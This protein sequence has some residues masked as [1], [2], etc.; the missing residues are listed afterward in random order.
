MPKVAIT[1]VERNRM[2]H[3]VNTI[4]TQIGRV[5]RK[6]NVMNFQALKFVKVTNIQKREAESFRQKSQVIRGHGRKKCRLEN[7]SMNTTL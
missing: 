4:T 5:A 3:P 7:N 6:V 1:V 2:R